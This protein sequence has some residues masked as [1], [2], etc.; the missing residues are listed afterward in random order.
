MLSVT[1]FYLLADPEKAQRLKAE[2]EPVSI[3]ST[4]ILS[5]KQLRDLPYL[6]SNQHHVEV[7]CLL[8]YSERALVGNCIRRSTV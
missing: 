1:M 5:Y 2:L 4:D 7:I 3:E 8:I 6:V